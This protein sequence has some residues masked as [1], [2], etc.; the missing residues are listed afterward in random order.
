MGHG[1]GEHASLEFVFDQERRNQGNPHAVDGGLA[2]HRKQFMA[3]PTHVVRDRQ[4]LRGEPLAPRIR[5][6]RLLQQGVMLELRRAQRAAR[7]DQ[8]GTAHRNQVFPHQGARLDPGPG[9]VAAI[10]GGIEFGFVEQERTGAGCHIERDVGMAAL[11]RSQPRH[12]PAGGE[13]RHHGQLQA[14]AQ[15]TA[16]HQVER[17]ALDRVQAQRHLAA[18]GAPRFTQGHAAFAAV[19]QAYTEQRLQSGNLAAH[20][21]LRQRQFGGG[22]GKTLVPGRCFKGHQGPGVG[23]FSAHGTAAL[24]D[25]CGNCTS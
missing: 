15:A 20:R 24:F 18:I 5:P 10:D 22:L 4:R 16:R 14:A 19:K 2:Q 12:Q 21:A 8:R 6:G 1:N 13:G 25:V 3:R 17:V 23:N 7:P 11:E 9:R